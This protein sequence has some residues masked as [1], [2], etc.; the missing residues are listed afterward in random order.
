MKLQN[1]SKIMFTGIRKWERIVNTR[2]RQY[3]EIK[4]KTAQVILPDLNS[5]TQHI[6]RAN[7]QAHYWVY[8]MTKDIQKCDPCLSVG[9]VAKKL[10]L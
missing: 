2:M 7:T 3:N 5:L 1:L 10:E 8:C 4:T 9:N 6:Q